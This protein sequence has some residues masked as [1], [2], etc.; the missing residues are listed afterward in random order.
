MKTIN[1]AEKLGQFSSQSDPQVVANYNGNNL[2]FFKFHGE[3]PFHVHPDT[4]DFLSV[5]KGEMKIDLTGQSHTVKQANYLSYQRAS[6]IAPVQKTNA[7][8]C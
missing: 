2:M 1:L 8:F 5:L 3:F 4:D 7:K 6:P